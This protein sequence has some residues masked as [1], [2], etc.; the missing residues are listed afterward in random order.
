MEEKSWYHRVRAEAFL[1]GVILGGFIGGIC[2][3]LLIVAIALVSTKETPT[4]LDVYRNKTDL[5]IT[6]QNDVTVDSVVVFKCKKR[7]I[8]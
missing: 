4:A 7:G 8:W 2:T 5:Q 6:Y 1:S 3:F